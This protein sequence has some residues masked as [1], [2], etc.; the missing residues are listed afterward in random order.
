MSRLKLKRQRNGLYRYGK[1]KPQKQQK[2]AAKNHE[3]SAK[4]EAKGK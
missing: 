1:K 2:K 3:K 4:K